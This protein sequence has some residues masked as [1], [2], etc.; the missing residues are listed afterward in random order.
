[1]LTKYLTDSFNELP[2]RPT[3]LNGAGRILHLIS[4]VEGQVESINTSH[5]EEIRQL[6]STVYVNVEVFVTR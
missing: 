6:A 2:E 4:H 5:L 1:M 3:R